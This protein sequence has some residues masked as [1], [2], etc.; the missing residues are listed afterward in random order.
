MLILRKQAGVTLI[1]LMV[2]VAIIA[3]LSILAIPSYSDWIGNSR[4]RNGAESVV[5]GL[6]LARAEAVRR[7]TAVQFQ[8][9]GAGTT[10]AWQVGCVA[11]TATCPAN[12]QSHTVGDGSSATV[13]F[14]MVVGGVNPV[15][16]NNLGRTATATSWNVDNTALTAANSRDLRVV[17]STGGTVRMC[18]PNVVAPDTRAC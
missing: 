10:S 17:V 3:I 15:A 11:V 12:I 9:T 4:L 18:D 13:S 2:I 7:N 6:Q 16:F 5:N 8:L 1:E 14:T